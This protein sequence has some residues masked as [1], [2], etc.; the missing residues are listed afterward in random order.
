MTGRTTRKSENPKIHNEF[1]AELK[2]SRDFIAGDQYNFNVPQPENRQDYLAQ[3]VQVQAVLAEIQMHPELT[4]TAA[5]E[6]QLAQEKME[7]AIAESQKEQP[8]ARR[9]KSAL[10]TVSDVMHSLDESLKTAMNLGAT[11]ATLGVLTDA[12]MKVFS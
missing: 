8:L 4:P 11:L 7:E 2:I 3:M 6:I 1:N 10:D 9:I 5:Q 12:A